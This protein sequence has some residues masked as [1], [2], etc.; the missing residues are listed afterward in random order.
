[1]DN[2]EIIFR[3]VLDRLSEDENLVEVDKWLLMYFAGTTRYEVINPIIANLIYRG[4]LAKKGN[5]FVVVTRQQ[6]GKYK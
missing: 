5:K 4:I 3:K 2:L 6:N 1:M